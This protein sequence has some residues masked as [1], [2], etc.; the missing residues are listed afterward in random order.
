MKKLTTLLLV[1]GLLVSTK[2]FAQTVDSVFWDLGPDNQVTSISPNLEV[3]A[4]SMTLH[5]PLAMGPDRDGK[6]AGP[7]AKIN[8]DAA[9]WG[10]NGTETFYMDNRFV[11]FTVSPK[12]GFNLHVDSVAFWM[13]CYG[14][15]GHFHAAVF[16]DRDTNFASKT[17]LDLDSAAY[18]VNPGLPDVRDEQNGP[19]H[20]TSYAINT[21][22]NDGSSFV[23]GF[24]PW[25]DGGA[26][27]SKYLVLWFVRVYGTTSPATGVE[28]ANALP[29]EFKLDQNYPNPFNPT[30]TITFET[31]KSS[32]VTLNVY[33]L[34]GQ[35][36]AALV[37]QNMEAG[38]HSVNFDAANL[39]SGIY[40]YQLR[41]DNF[42]SIKKM[43]LLK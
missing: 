14:T 25:F 6:L 16:W 18:G 4:D 3:T 17:L 2:L 28:D 19:L 8:A 43:T 22:I 41:T 39:P 26:S 32:F 31:P 11:D 7:A 29:K 20:D 9:G 30:T 21:T 35:K 42:N 12:P 23:L 34:L 33:N 37:N 10:A 13:G 1:A 38:S 27:T 36:V 5:G 40:L 24:F 15:H